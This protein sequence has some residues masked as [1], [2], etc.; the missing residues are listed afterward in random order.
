MA[1]FQEKERPPI[2]P[3]PVS[4]NR[5]MRRRKS[6]G[7]ISMINTETT[8]LSIDLK[9]THDDWIRNSQYGEENWQQGGFA[10][11]V[12]RG[13]PFIYPYLE[14]R[15]KIPQLINA[16]QKIQQNNPGI[17]PTYA[18]TLA[19]L[20]NQDIFSHK[21]NGASLS[22]IAK[23][24]LP[25]E[26]SDIK[27]INRMLY[28]FFSPGRGKSLI[29]RYALL[30]LATQKIAHPEK[31]MTMSP[32][33]EHLY[34]R[35][36]HYL[37]YYVNFFT[38][39]SPTREEQEWFLITLGWV[40]RWLIYSLGCYLP[41][42]LGLTPSSVIKLYQQQTTD[43][44]SFLH[45]SIRKEM[46]KQI[47]FSFSKDTLP[48]DLVDYQYYNSQND[49]TATQLL[50]KFYGSQDLK[51]SEMASAST[52][53]EQLL[54]RLGTYRKTT[55]AEIRNSSNN[56][57]ILNLPE[58]SAI[59]KVVIT[60]QRQ[61]KQVLIF[62]LKFKDGQTHLTL[63]I[64]SRNKLYGLP[65]ELIRENPH[66]G[67]FLLK[68]ILTPFLEEMRQKHPNIET[69]PT[70]QFKLLSG[71][72][73]S[74]QSTL[75]PSK[76]KGTE[77]IDVEPVKIPK[78]KLTIPTPIRQIFIQTQEPEPRSPIEE[79]T[80]Q[81]KVFHT[82]KRVTQMLGGKPRPQD[83]EQIM[84]TIRRFEFGQKLLKQISWSEGKRVVLKV[85]K[86]RIILNPLGRN[87]YS[88]EDIGWRKDIYRAYSDNL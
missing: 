14:T 39:S 25:L 88:L 47:R 45:S 64:D 13:A 23:M 42:R 31:Q 30:F 1:S 87:S 60:N 16:I 79:K 4:F 52:D 85:R 11:V 37:D 69:K 65:E 83:I 86:W 27:K 38:T 17:Q 33:L 72:V 51:D 34:S 46:E 76:E 63:E 21:V 24:P 67:D 48:G 82:R 66:I 22:D 56:R 75:I 15:W 54:K 61:N 50:L 2:L 32:S 73:I 3:E 53:S 59:D 77:E 26:R 81:F 84:E 44:S 9:K 70:S 36:T 29:V 6:P 74:P 62:I 7:E 20:K 57:L 28:T 18:E 5:A 41:A 71:F 19:D 40:G 43:V 55:Y 12:Y 68:D 10:K 58:N 8:Q 80:R 78:R 49:K 35:M